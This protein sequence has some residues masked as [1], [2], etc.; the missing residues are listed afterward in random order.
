MKKTQRHPAHSTSMAPSVGPMAAPR[1]AMP[2]QT[3]MAIDRRLTGNSS[4][5]SASE[6]G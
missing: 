2:P 4:R 6:A 5:S 3:P 1:P